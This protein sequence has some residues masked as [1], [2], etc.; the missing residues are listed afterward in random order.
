MTRRVRVLFGVAAVAMVLLFALD[1]RLG[2]VW[3]SLSEVWGGLFGGGEDD[4]V[5][6][7]ML[8]FRLPKAV[9]AVLAGAAL[10]ASGLEMQTLFRNPLAGPYVLGISS[11]ASLGVALFLLGTPLFALLPAGVGDAVWNVGI[12][13]AAWIGAGA[14]FMLIVAVSRRIKDIMA[15]LIIG[16]MLGS[17]AGAV[18][19]VLQYFSNEGMV[20]SFV[21]WTMGSLG[22]VTAEQLWVLA[23]IVVVALGMS[24]A[25]IKPLDALMLGENYARTMGVNVRRTRNLVFVNTTLLAG[26]VTAFCGP[27]GFLGLAAPH[28]ARMLSGEA[29]HGV[30]MPASMILGAAIMLGCD[31]LTGVVGPTPLPINTI[32]AL[33]GIP[34]IILVVVRGR[35]FF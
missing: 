35:K 10:G 31:V 27:I 2:T 13:G 6:Y 33:V 1:I 4:T 7:I 15:I 22:G 3:L 20:K 24:I 12:T 30:L 26:T 18:V 16:M 17:V 8:G 19:E 34:V 23:P 9:V 5:S 28:I 21:V 32:T 14:I 11:G 29:R 25:V